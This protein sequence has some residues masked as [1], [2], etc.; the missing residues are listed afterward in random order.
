MIDNSPNSRVYKFK[1][2]AW[3]G[4]TSVTWPFGKLE[5]SKEYIV[6]G[7]EGLPFSKSKIER[8]FAR[9]EIDKIEI[10]KLQS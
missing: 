2:G 5:V 7:F 8:R 9:E 1:G 10:K 6:I 3:I 4:F